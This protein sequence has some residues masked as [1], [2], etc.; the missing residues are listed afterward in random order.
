[1]T[2][3]DVYDGGGVCL[4]T[5][6]SYGCSPSSE[7]TY[8]RTNERTNERMNERTNERMN[9]R[10][11]RG[12]DERTELFC[13]QRRPSPQNQLCILPPIFRFPPVYWSPLSVISFIR[14]FIR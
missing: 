10:T 11:N 5:C 9:E 13:G 14:S 1:M 3:V 4:F 12:V 7:R 6:R 2:V 8:E